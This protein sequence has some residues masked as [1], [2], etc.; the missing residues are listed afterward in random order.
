MIHLPDIF[1]FVHLLQF[2]FS[3]VA[4]GNTSSGDRMDQVDLSTKI[5]KDAYDRI[6]SFF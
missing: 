3:A 6:V 5:I 2:S 1:Y 4:M